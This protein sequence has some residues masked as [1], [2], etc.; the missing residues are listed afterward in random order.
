ME[1]HG[2]R[3]RS[4][5][6]DHARVATGIRVD[7]QA[8]LDAANTQLLI[9]NV[10]PVKPRFIVDM[11]GSGVNA[12]ALTPSFHMSCLDDLVQY[13]TPSCFIVTADISSYYNNFPLA[14]SARRNFAV[15]WL[16]T[17]LY[18]VISFG[19]GPAPYYCST[20]TAE[21]LLW[22][23]AE[24][25]PAHLHGQLGHPSP[26]SD[27]RPCPD[28][29]PLEAIIARPGF[30]FNAAKRQCSQRVVHLGLLLDTVDVSMGFDRSNSAVTRDTLTV[31]LRTLT[32]G[33]NIS[34][35]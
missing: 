7:D 29:R 2:C 6:L 16:F 31:Y 22:V 1:F 34:H 30:R 25:I 3:H 8:A 12:H 32:E 19:F 33:H 20:C 18:W 17:Y 10:P 28:R 24:G 23:L 4:S 5:D 27:R 15:F 35:A 21:M 13:I 14:E 11:T 26:Y 9:L